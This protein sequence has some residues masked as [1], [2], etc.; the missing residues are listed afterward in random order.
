MKNFIIDCENIQA[1]SYPEFL[2]DRY[3]NGKVRPWMEKAE[4]KDLLA[5]IYDDL[6]NHSKAR[7]IR[8]CA[9]RLTFG[10]DEEGKKQLTQAYF[11]RVR[12]C[13]MC[14]WRRLLKLRFQMS[15][16]VSELLKDDNLSFIFLTLTIKNCVPLQL[17]DA[18]D[19]VNQGWDRFLH[20]KEIKTIL[21]GFYKGLEV[22]HNVNYVSDDFN[23]YHP[24]IHAL[25]VVDKSYF[26]K[27]YIKHEKFAQFWQKSVRADYYP[28]VNVKSA[29]NPEKSVAELCKYSVKDCD[30]ILPWD[31]QLSLETVKILD[32][33]LH[34]RRFVSMGGI[35]KEMHKR[36]NL[37]APED[38]D[39][40]KTGDEDSG[41]DFKSY[42]T[43]FWHSGYH[44]YV[45][46]RP[47]QF[48][49]V[50]R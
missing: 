38:G 3:A 2:C 35:F 36:L 7:R 49:S 39:L 16:I 41:K 26:K 25:L 47:F 1:D 32:E 27:H 19:E 21:K 30:Y 8:E 13:P 33:A 40:R 24:H 46:G 10:L 50:S 44:Q 22:T 34:N 42:E 17:K 6:G 37:D 45:K 12:L 29:K 18:L 11:C 43:Y 48:V 4:Q 23:T 9:S 5:Q 14:V 31:W 15:R 28:I 20:T